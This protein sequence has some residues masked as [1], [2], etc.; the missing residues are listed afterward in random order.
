MLLGMTLLLVGQLLLLLGQPLLLLLDV[1][2]H[3]GQFPV[4]VFD[5][6]VDLYRQLLVLL[7]AFGQVH[8]EL[9]HSGDE[10]LSFLSELE[11]FGVV[12]WLLGKLLGKFGVGLLQIC[13]LC[14]ELLGFSVGSLSG[15]DCLESSLGKLGS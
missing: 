6:L 2:V 12:L 13:E 1:A 4:A 15:L 10:H 3:A 5:H 14:L 8:L 9:V 7:P 11:Q